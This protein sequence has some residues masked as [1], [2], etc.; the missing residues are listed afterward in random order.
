MLALS[1]VWLSGFRKMGSASG[2]ARVS[3]VR[4]FWCLS[5]GKQEKGWKPD[6]MIDVR[7]G[8]LDRRD[9]KSISS[10]EMNVSLRSVVVA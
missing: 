3:A 8:R 6:V 2:D 9:P 10:R 5:C 4:E 7:L 1:P